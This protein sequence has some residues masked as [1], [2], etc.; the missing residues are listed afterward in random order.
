MANINIQLPAL[1]ADHSIEIEVRINGNKIK[2]H[3]RV[4]IIQW[5]ECTEPKNH[6]Q[7]LK[8][9]LNTYDQDWKLIQIGGPT[10]KNIPLM[11]KQVSN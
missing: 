4:E 10:E 11:F 5:D 3:Y 6:A 1:E 8:E 7:C 2:H 9:K